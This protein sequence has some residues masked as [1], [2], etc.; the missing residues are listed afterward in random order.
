MQ[1]IVI[2]A[3]C[4]LFILAM[5]GMAPG[6]KLP[7][8]TVEK[9]YR[10]VVLFK[11]KEDATKEQIQEIVTAFGELK[12]QINTVLRYE[13]G[14]DVSPEKLAKGFSHCF[15]VTFRSKQDLE[16]YLPHA[17]HQAFT[18][19]LKPILADVLVVDYWAES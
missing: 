2:T 4:S 5:I 12:N 8:K 10:H 3:I 16:K 11:F 13:Y 17:A 19:K 15:L 1:N 18:A 7:E 6:D 9:V 14:T